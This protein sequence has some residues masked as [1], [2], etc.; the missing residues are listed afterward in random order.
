MSRCSSGKLLVALKKAIAEYHTSTMESAGAECMQGEVKHFQKHSTMLA[1]L[2]D[3]DLQVI[4][5]LERGTELVTPAAP[6]GPSIVQATARRLQAL[7][8]RFDGTAAQCQGF[9]FQLEVYF[10]TISPA[11]SDREKQ[12]TY[13]WRRRHSASPQV[14]V[15]SGAAGSF[16]G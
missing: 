12:L 16:I 4:Q 2:V 10:D 13:L 8:Q 9:L 15:D 5:R 14:L 6:P 1:N 7:L 3:R 11:P